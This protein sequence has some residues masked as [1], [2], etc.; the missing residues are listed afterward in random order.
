MYENTSVML[1]IYGP[2]QIRGIKDAPWGMKRS[3]NKVKKLFTL[4][5]SFDQIPLHYAGQVRRQH[6]LYLFVVTVVP[7][8][9]V[10]C[11]IVLL[12]V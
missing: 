7:L 9:S 12:R 3:R 5:N 6:I 1:H 8:C 2:W 11:A 10:L 4:G